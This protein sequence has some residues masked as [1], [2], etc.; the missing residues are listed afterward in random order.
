MAVIHPL[1]KE[2]AAPE[3]HGIYDTLAHK[4]GHM[5]NIFAVMAHRPNVLRNFL[6]AYAAIMG[7]GTVA[8]R[9]K[10]LAYLKTSLINGC[11]Y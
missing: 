6:P 3:V 8:L 11:A 7:E 1:S 10:L 9:H 2:E 4:Y 5:P